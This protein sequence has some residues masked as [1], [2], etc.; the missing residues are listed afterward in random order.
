MNEPR[1]FLVRVWQHLSQFRAS[2]RGVDD[3]EPQLFDEPARLGEF[4]RQASVELP[5][6]TSPSD[7]PPANARQTPPR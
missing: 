1:L 7:K 6:S 2:V 4:F 5:R 3:S